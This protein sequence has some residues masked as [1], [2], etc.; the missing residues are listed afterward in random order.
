MTR[1][2]DNDNVDDG[3]VPVWFISGSYRRRVIISYSAARVGGW[4]LPVKERRPAND[5][6]ILC[7]DL[8]DCRRML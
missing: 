7:L 1:Y 5:P 2:T 6:R 4:K 8:V 3:S